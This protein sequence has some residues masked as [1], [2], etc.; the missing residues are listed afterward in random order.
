[1]LNCDYKIVDYILSGRLM[2]VLCRL[3]HPSQSA[4]LRS[5]HGILL[6]ATVQAAID[7]VH[8][9]NSPAVFF[10]ADSEKA[11][12]RV[13]WEW[14]LR[15]LKAY[16]FHDAFIPMLFTCLRGQ[17]LYCSVNGHLSRPFRRTRGFTQGSMLADLLFILSQEPLLAA[18][19]S[20]KV[21]S[22]VA[23]P[24]GPPLRVM[25][26]ADD[27]TSACSTAADICLVLH[28]FKVFGRA[29]GARLNFSKSFFVPVGSLINVV[30]VPN[31]GCRWIVDCDNGDPA[32]SFTLCGIPLT[33]RPAR[34]DPARHLAAFV[35]DIVASILT[36]LARWSQFHAP[37][38]ARAALVNSR[39]LSKLWHV[40]EVVP[41]STAAVASIEK[42][43]LNFVY[44]DV[45]FRPSRPAAHAPRK[46]GGLGLINVAAKVTA[47]KSRWIARF[48]DF[49]S[50]PRPRPPPPWCA[51]AG[52][53]FAQLP[54]G[55][56]QM[57]SPSVPFNLT[58]L[59][60]QSLWREVF[61]AW[62]SIQG[63]RLSP[64]SSVWDL[65]LEPVSHNCL[66]LPESSSAASSCLRRHGYR[67]VT[68]VW[69]SG[70]SAWHLRYHPV[71]GP[72]SA[73]LHACWD[74]LLRNAASPIPVP[75]PGDHVAAWYWGPCA[76]LLS[77]FPVFFLWVYYYAA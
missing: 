52:H 57:L 22:G 47:F 50:S 1:M 18:L 71:A 70:R 73:R 58:M 2:P 23:M 45:T 75:T 7:Y 26:F 67:S 28:T 77:R 17:T 11:F 49:H 6:P 24:S 30:V 59:P 56:S 62:R 36:T 68:D 38:E 69:D 51:L 66:L 29:S 20:P 39:L 72:L 15:V 31:T 37:P 19:R 3:I 10:N 43:S 35:E 16:G 5:R 65:A 9:S 34:L 60:R 27:T 25:A 54:S 53:A 40:A 76:G 33:T 74:S 64:P 8:D 48:A 21:N 63:G 44:A 55:L 14:L 61:L 32:P 12:D 13:E 46:L 42:A 4:Y 41:I